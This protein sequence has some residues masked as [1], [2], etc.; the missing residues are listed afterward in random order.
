MKFKKKVLTE[1]E[2]NKD[3]EGKIEL[4]PLIRCC[5]SCIA[6]IQR[7]GRENFFFETCTADDCIMNLLEKVHLSAGH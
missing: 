7:V 2:E 1:T 6:R 5:A 3:E 4:M